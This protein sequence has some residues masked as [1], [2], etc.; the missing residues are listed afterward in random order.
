MKP[1]GTIVSPLTNAQN[2]ETMK[3]DESTKERKQSTGESRKLN[4]SGFSERITENTVALKMGEP[5]R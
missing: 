1:N 4:Y 3:Q 2:G 5:K